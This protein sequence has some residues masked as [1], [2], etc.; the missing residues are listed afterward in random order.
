[1]QGTHARPATGDRAQVRELRD[2]VSAA[3]AEWD[4][5]ESYRRSQREALSGMADANRARPLEFDESGFPVA[6]RRLSFV[7][8]VRR[9]L[10]EG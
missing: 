2:A 3:L 6:Q 1:M 4:G 9:L 5:A 10:R 8:R 7:R